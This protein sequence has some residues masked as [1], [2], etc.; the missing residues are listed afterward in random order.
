M[1]R[2]TF[3]AL[4]AGAVVGAPYVTRAQATQIRA[5]TVAVESYALMYYAQ[6]QGFF[7]Q[8]GLDVTLQT[9]SGGGA[10]SAALAGGSLD[11]ACAN[12]GVLSNA[13]SRSIPISVIAPGGAYNSASPT[14]VL[15]TAKNA[16][17]AAARDLNGKTVALSTVKDLQQAAVMKWM[18]TN[19]GDAS[20]LKFVEITVPEMAAALQAGRVDA[21][22][23]LEPSLTAVKNEIR[24]FAKPYDAI[25]KQFFITLHAAQNSFLERNPAAAKQFMAALHQAAAWAN[26]NH[27]ATGAVLVKLT[28]IPQA[29]I[30]KMARVV[31]VETLDPALIQPVIDATAQYK[32]LAARFQAQEL[33]WAQART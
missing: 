21:A 4:A 19:G 18:D 33:F 8:A 29:T 15:A 22:T 5:G 17:F 23:L 13:H 11:I 7:K 10:V 20:T 16:T 24:V 1:K 27:E 30:D 3:G 9:F 31:Y 32:F 12:V 26:R 25:A 28:K 6:E 2:A 14:T